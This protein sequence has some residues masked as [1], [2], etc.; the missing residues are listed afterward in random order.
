MLDWKKFDQAFRQ[1]YEHAREVLEQPR[2]A[3][4]VQVPETVQAF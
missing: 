2:E 3:P 1:G 4:P